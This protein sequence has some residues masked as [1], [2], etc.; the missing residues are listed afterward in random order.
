MDG[1]PP[2]IALALRVLE[3]H[4][5]SSGRHL[6]AHSFDWRVACPVITYLAFASA[7]VRYVS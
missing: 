4:A 2:P 7:P 5:V 1:I 6:D 3:Q